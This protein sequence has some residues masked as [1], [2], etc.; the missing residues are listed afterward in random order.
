[1]PFRN[2]GAYGAAFADPNGF[3]FGY[4]VGSDSLMNPYGFPLMSPDASCQYTSPA[5]PVPMSS[6]MMVNTPSPPEYSFSLAGTPESQQFAANSTQSDSLSPLEINNFTSPAQD[7]DVQ[8]PPSAGA[9]VH[10]DGNAAAARRSYLDM[11]N[12]EVRSHGQKRNASYLGTES[13]P[14]SN[15]SAAA[16]M[17]SQQQTPAT[18]SASPPAV[19][20]KSRRSSTDASPEGIHDEILPLATD[21]TP[22]VRTTD[23]AKVRHNIVERRYRENINAQV[24]LLRESIVATVHAKEEQQGVSA[25]RLGADELKRL[26]KAAVIAA[27]TKQIRRARTENERLLEEHRSLQAQVQELESLV[28]CGDCPLMKLTV[29]LSLESPTQPP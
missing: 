14:T 23:S 21:G 19:P 27:A 11:A 4:D 2:P 24:D 9:S 25:S 8:Y 16:P 20:V 18:S 10:S 13:P 15:L 28:K 6:I 26:T 29:D 22:R 3:D 12:A 17:A 7:Q 1:M 5:L